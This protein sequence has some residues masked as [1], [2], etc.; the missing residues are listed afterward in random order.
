M[1]PDERAAWRDQEAER[2]GLTAEEKAAWL[3][4]GGSCRY[5]Y[6]PAF[7]DEDEDDYAY[8]SYQ[9]GSARRAS[10]SRGGPDAV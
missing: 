9:S 7:T 6:G 2:R 4:A 10:G 1:T 3:A 5:F 8:S